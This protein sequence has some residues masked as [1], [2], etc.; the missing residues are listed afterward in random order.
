MVHHR[1]AAH[2]AICRPLLEASKRRVE[3]SF[4]D[5]HLGRAQHVPPAGTGRHL[6]EATA[7]KSDVYG[8]EVPMVDLSR[9]LREQPEVLDAVMNAI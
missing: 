1:Y 9:P 4:S 2:A 5:R 8:I 3:L 6:R 7:P